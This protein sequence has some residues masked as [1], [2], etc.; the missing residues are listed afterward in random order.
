MNTLATL[1]AELAALLPPGI[2]MAVANA[3]PATAEL[4]PAEEPAATGMVPRRRTEFALGRHCAR[5]AM[6][7]LGET[8]AAVPRGAD[9]APTWPA[10]LAGSISHA[11]DT[12]AAL[13]ARSRDYRA[14]GLDIET[15][16]PLEPDVMELVLRPRELRSADGERAKVLFSI[17]EAIYKCIHPV[18]GVYVDFR[19]MEVEIGTD[20]TS[21]RARP[22]GTHWDPARIA[23]LRGRYAIAAGWVLS[24]AWLADP[25]SA[26]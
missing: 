21:F 2:A 26:V 10:G 9:R 6:Q 12:A 19:E 20:G 17:K 25:G 16:G 5:L 18:V 23:G 8:P 3:L 7:R 4:L 15:A 24:V 1:E 11:G 22:V 13:V 14:V